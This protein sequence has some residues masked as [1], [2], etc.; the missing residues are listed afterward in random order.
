MREARPA[1]GASLEADYLILADRA[2]VVN[3]KLYVM[4]GGWDRLGLTGLPGP[5]DFDVALGVLVGYQ[6]TNTR[7]E[8]E[9]RLE[10]DD[11]RL[12]LAPIKAEFELGRPAG[13][14]PAHTQRFQMVL[15]GPFQ[16]PGPGGFHWALSLNGERRAL[17]RFQVERVGP[18]P[19]APAVAEEGGPPR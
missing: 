6:E 2:E 8:L 12:V 13:M 18:N 19:A 3:G 9:L 5:A 14:R 11:N 17:T 10:D 15:R 1:Q 4:G 7:Q 16:I